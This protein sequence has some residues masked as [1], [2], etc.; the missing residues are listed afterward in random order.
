MK[1]WEAITYLVNDVLILPQKVYSY[2]DEEICLKFSP[3]RKTLLRLICV[4]TETHKTSDIM[5]A[6][7]TLT[8]CNSDS[9]LR[10]ELLGGAI[11]LTS[12][13]RG[14]NACG[15]KWPVC[16]RN[17][18]CETGPST[19]P[20]LWIHGSKL[21]SLKWCCI[22]LASIIIQ[23]VVTQIVNDSWIMLH[24]PSYF[25]L[26][27][28]RSKRLLLCSR[29]SAPFQ[30]CICR[31]TQINRYHDCNNDADLFRNGNFPG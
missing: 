31:Y 2:L 27:L 10:Y 5:I 14:M 18:L 7:K 19:F 6:I 16:M 12:W 8:Y 4:L 13:L 29:N 25:F 20:S 28:I 30:C 11:Y 23:K 15:R 1:F 26:R 22:L 17:L 9:L 3:C 24:N 21:V